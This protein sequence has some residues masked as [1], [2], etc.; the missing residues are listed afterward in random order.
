MGVRRFGTAPL[1]G[2]PADEMRRDHE[3]LERL[4]EPVGDCLVA[5]AVAEEGEIVVGAVRDAAPATPL[6]VPCEP[7]RTVGQELVI[8]APAILG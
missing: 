1:I 6:A 8:A 5:M 3:A 2:E 4:V 7:T